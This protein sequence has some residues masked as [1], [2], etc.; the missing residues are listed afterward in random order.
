VTPNE[1]VANRDSSG[2]DNSSAVSLSADSAAI[3]AETRLE[4]K[5]QRELADVDL[6]SAP[7]DSRES[8]GG[9]NGSESAC[10]TRR[11][12]S[13]N[14]SLSLHA[15]AAASNDD[16]ASKATKQT[17]KKGGRIYHSQVKAE[18]EVVPLPAP[19]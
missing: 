12:G 5:C 19:D 13:S 4:R 1:L 3:H 2:S 14:H 6:T 8:G 18:R 7:D 10:K 17:K 11:R 15:A 16:T 9:S